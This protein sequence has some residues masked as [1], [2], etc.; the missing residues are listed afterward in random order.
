MKSK[1]YAIDLRASDKENMLQKFRRLIGMLEPEKIID[2]RDLT[3]IKIH[4]GER[5]NTSYIRPIYARQVVDAVKE[6]GGLPFL[7]DA[8]TLYV[9]MRSNAAEH[10]QTAIENGFAY[11]VVNAPVTI[12]DGLKGTSYH[13]VDVGL[14]NVQTAYI[15]S[16]VVE[17]DALVS[18]SHFKLHEVTGIGGAIKN[19]GMGGAARRGKMDQHSGISP[20][21]KNKKC[22]ACGDCLPHCQ[23]EAIALVDQNGEDKAYID[24][25]KCVGCA[26]CV[27]VCPQGAI[28]VQW[29]KSIP[30]LMKKMAEYTVA[31]VRGKADKCMYFNFITQVSPACDCHP[32][33]DAPLVAD[34]GVLASTDPVAIDQASTDLINQAPGL[35]GTCLETCPGPGQDKVRATYPHI[36]W[37]L[38]L[39]HAQALGLGSRDYDLIWLENRL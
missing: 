2:H 17:A 34:I 6:A 13:A 1:V 20:K 38:Q 37:E 26:E 8:N 11:A 39:D 25:E 18:L 24:P 29:N 3:A 16:D 7:T 36:E 31:A 4:F 27:R 32:S 19:V 33:A 15:G 22:I 10:I 23:Q 30:S 35:T 14:E 5:G 12:A 9:G 21:V 28:L